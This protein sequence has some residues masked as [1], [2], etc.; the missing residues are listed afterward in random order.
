MLPLRDHEPSLLRPVVTV[1]L[2]GLNVVVFFLE[3]TA[4]NID[5]FVNAWALVPSQISPSDPQSIVPF[6]TAQFLHGGVAHIGFNMWYL[7]IFGDN[8]EGRLG[9]GKFLAFY[10]ISGIVAAVAELPF[11]WE[12][13]IPM[14]GASGAIAGV[15]GMYLACFPHHRV[16][17]LMP[18]FL[19]F[20]TRVTLPAGGVLFFWFITQL[21]SG[22]ASIAGSAASGG[23]AWWAHIGG[24]AFGWIVGK[25]LKHPA[26]EVMPRDWKS[27]RHS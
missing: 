22:T 17:A 13:S 9:H 2:I 25:S 6:I 1:S 11:L 21:F 10:L 27:I 8:V 16:D 4:P 14:L 20:W 5:A 7:W 24:F 18:T 12:S 15:L 26:V 3:I 19:G 23:V